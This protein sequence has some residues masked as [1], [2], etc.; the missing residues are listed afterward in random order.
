MDQDIRDFVPASCELLAL[1]E[2]THREPAFG[3]VRNE[4]LVRLVDLGFRSIAIEIDRVAALSVNDFVRGGAGDLDRVL[5]EGF[6]HDFGELDANRRLVAW[7]REYNEDRSAEER[8]AFHGFDTPGENFSAPSPRGYLEYARDRL[9]LDLD[10]AGL[11]GDDE[12]W[13]RAEAV[14]DPAMSPGI[15]EEAVRLRVIADGMLGELYARAPELIAATSRAEWSGT[16]TRLTAGIGLLRYH[17][18]C[19]RHPEQAVRLRAQI[20]TRDALMA[21]NLLDIRDIEAERGATLVFTH[22]LH[23]RRTPSVW[24]F[25]DEDLD[26]FSAGAIVGSLVGERYACVAGSLGRSEGL[27]LGEPE[28]DT[29]EGALQAGVT[30]WGLRAATGLAPARTR[31]DTT[32]E[33]GYFPL[34][35]ATVAG[36]DAVLHIADAGAIVKTVGS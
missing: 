9:G 14:M 35:E 5:E 31:T 26:W 32:P 20:A 6:S 1:G 27:G 18:Q 8:V 7:L 15:T 3:L 10:I 36:V 22:N 25:G 29:Y 23:L 4:L 19:A 16:R 28:A 34:E 17:E 12:R 30:T 21:E 11:T 13:S 2:P 33:K 24:R